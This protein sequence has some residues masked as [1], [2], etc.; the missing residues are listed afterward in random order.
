MNHN[1]YTLLLP[2]SATGLEIKEDSK[3]SVTRVTTVLF[4]E[5]NCPKPK[6]PNPKQIFFV[7]DQKTLMLSGDHDE[8]RKQ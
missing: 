1:I 2:S 4:E 7:K 6:N 5:K 8:T 3:P